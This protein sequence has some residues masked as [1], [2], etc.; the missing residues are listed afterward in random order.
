M[1]LKDLQ[2]QTCSDH[3]LQ[4]IGIIAGIVIVIFALIYW[5]NASSVHKSA[6]VTQPVVLD[7][8]ARIAAELASSP[9]VVSQQDINAVSAQLRA[10]T[11]TVTDAQRQ[12]VLNALQ[13][14]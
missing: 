6:P 1:D 2:T 3:R 13:G 5:W 12:A 7:D 9:V 11:T 10:S 4:R 8:R 14:K